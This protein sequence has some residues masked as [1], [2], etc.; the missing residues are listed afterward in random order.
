MWKKRSENW[1][2][3]YEVILTYLKSAC[4]GIIPSISEHGIK[5][6]GPTHPI[7]Q[8]GNLSSHKVTHGAIHAENSVLVNRDEWC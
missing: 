7:H 4:N 1:K 6:N 2:K 8:D 3:V 5:T